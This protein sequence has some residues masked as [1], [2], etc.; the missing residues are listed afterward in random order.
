MLGIESVAQLRGVAELRPPATDHAPQEHSVR[1]GMASLRREKRSRDEQ[2]YFSRIPTFHRTI[3]GGATAD[4]KI[5]A[6][7][8][9]PE[10]D[11]STRG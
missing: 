11:A 10:T 7:R 8:L 9:E 5:R 2:D 1:P 3:P 4:P 6:A